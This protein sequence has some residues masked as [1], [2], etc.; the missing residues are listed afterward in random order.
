[1]DHNTLD[2]Y[3]ASMFRKRALPNKLRY[4]LV[5][6]LRNNP[7]KRMKI[8][9]VKAQLDEVLRSMDERKLLIL[10]TSQSGKS[11]LFKQLKVTFHHGYTSE[12]TFCDVDLIF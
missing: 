1:M 5:N 12:G 10:G 11:T 2:D 4:L 6:M 7:I 3:I 9:A 8:K